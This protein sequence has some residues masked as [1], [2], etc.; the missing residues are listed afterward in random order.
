MINT[1]SSD[2][3]VDVINTYSSDPKVA[4]KVDF[5]A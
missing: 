2:P 4:P 1:Y 3:K 5:A